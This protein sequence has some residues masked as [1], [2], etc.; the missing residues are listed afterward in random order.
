MVGDLSNSSFANAETLGRYFAQFTLRA[1]TRKLE[2]EI[3][4][5]VFTDDELGV[6]HLEFD[7]SDFTRGDPAVRWKNHENAVRNDILT[8]NEIRE[9]E[10]F[11]PREGGDDA[12]TAPSGDP[13][14]ADNDL[15]STD[16]PQPVQ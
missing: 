5:A 6:M 2:A 8:R 1:W 9:I 4:R 7:L 3:A 16:Q 11:N 12:S 14:P 15:A 13:G 10:G